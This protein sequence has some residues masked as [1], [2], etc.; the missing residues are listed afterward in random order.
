MSSLATKKRRPRRKDRGTKSVMAK[1]EASLE[2]GDFYSALQMYK[3]LLS[4][5]SA[6]EYEGAAKLAEELGGVLLPRVRAVQAGEVQEDVRLRGGGRSVVGEGRGGESE[7]Q[8]QGDAVHGGPPSRPA[9]QGRSIRRH[10]PGARSPRVYRSM[11]TRADASRAVTLAPRSLAD[12]RRREEGCT[13]IGSATT[14]PKLDGDRIRHESQRETHAPFAGRAPGRCTPNHRCQNYFGSTAT[15]HLQ[16]TATDRRR[17]RR[18][19]R[20]KGC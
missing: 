18:K 14:N 15:T 10:A 8:G 2:D 4:R 1:L 19:R 20:K 9:R 17:R 7:E 6:D 16:S 12:V 3:T 5:S 13:C 11:A